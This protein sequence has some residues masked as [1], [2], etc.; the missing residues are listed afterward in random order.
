MATVTN[1]RDLA[2]RHKYVG[3]SGITWPSVTTILGTADHGKSGGMAG[4][5]AKLTRE[6]LD[7]RREWKAKAETGT[8]VHGYIEQWVKGETVDCPPGDAGFLDAAEAFVT[9]HDPQWVAVEQVVVWEQRGGVGTDERIGY[10]GRFDAIARLSNVEGVEDG[11]PYL[12]DWKSGREYPTEHACQ[13]AAYANAGGIV[14][15]DTAGEL[16]PG[17]Q[18]LPQIDRLA[19]VYFWN[20]GTF[21]LADYTHLRWT[22]AAYF[23]CLTEGWFLHKD[24]ERLHKEMTVA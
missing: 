13:L 1:P 14:R 2:D 8:R 18:P 5:A 16:L 20:D 7:Y 21:K 4:A 19:C 11:T 6:G 24:L 10:G 12:L 17:L 15:Y 23:D 3:P 22:A 9:A